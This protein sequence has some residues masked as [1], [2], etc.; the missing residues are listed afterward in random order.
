VAFGKGI[1]AMIIVAAEPVV[2]GQG[3]AGVLRARSLRE[4][5]RDRQ[6]EH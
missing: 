1:A 5:E 6:H 3:R 2:N 4:P